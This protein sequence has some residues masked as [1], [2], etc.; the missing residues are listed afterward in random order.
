MKL[1]VLCDN[2]AYCREEQGLRK[3][4]AITLGL[5]RLARDTNTIEDHA[6]CVRKSMV[7][8]ARSKFANYTLVA[9]K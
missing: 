2:Q 8:N 3:I 5:T 9:N 6:L 1:I 7:K 4:Q